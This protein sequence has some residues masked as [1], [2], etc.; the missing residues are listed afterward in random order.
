MEIIITLLIISQIFNFY[1]LWKKSP[2]V[3][4]K[5]TSK[6]ESWSNDIELVLTNILDNTKRLQLIHK[7]NYLILRYYLFMIRFCLDGF[8]GLEHDNNTA[9]MFSRNELNT[10]AGVRKL[11]QLVAHEY[12]HQWNV[13]R[14]RPREL[15]PYNYSAETITASLWFAEG[16]TSY[17]DSLLILRAG[18]CSIADYFDDL[19]KDINRYLCTPNY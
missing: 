13:R 1:L 11:F 12:L 5:V 6:E 3:Q 16:I 9:L 19:G 8:G 2:T 4:Q 18:L 14:L 7:N 10:P 15:T 17:Y